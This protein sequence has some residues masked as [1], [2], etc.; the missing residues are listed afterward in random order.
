MLGF[1]YSDKRNVHFE[2]YVYSAFNAIIWG[3]YFKINFVRLPKYIFLY[4]GS[5]NNNKKISAEY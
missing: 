4:N 1:N 2:G 5:K 3:N